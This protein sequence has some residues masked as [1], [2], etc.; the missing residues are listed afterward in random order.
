[1]TKAATGASLLAAVLAVAPVQAASKGQSPGAIVGVG[2]GALIP[3]DNLA[4]F[5]DTSYLVQSRTLFVEKIFGWRA[6][7]YYGDTDGRRGADG[8]RVFGVDF[9]VLLKFGSPSAFGYVYGGA[10]Y[11]ELTFTSAEP[12]SGAP[13]RQGGHDWC[14]AGAR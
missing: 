14:W 3:Q 4:E 7:A 6:G 12:A 8:G 9:D 5:N 13:L 2:V 10:G 1:M 11:G